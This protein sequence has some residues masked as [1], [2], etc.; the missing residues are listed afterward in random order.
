MMTISHCVKNTALVLCCGLAL[1]ACDLFANPEKLKADTSAALTARNFSSAAQSAE[2]WTQ[3]APEQYEAYFALAQAKAQAGD[4]NAALVALEKAIKKGLK[5]DVQ[6]ESN[7]NLDPIKSMVAYQDLMKTNFPGRAAKKA[8]APD[9][10]NATVSITEEDG[11]QVLRAGDV[12]LQV[13]AMK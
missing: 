13:P 5:D 10:D 11:K 1:S 12:V 4:K 9:Q 8:Q 2:Q 3:K 6:I 7:T